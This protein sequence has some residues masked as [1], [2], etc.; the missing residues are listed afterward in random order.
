MDAFV[1]VGN[2]SSEEDYQIQFSYEERPDG[3]EAFTTADLEPGWNLVAPT[4]V[5]YAVATDSDSLPSDGQAFKT[6]NG[7]IVSAAQLL[8]GGDR[9]PM[10]HGE[11]KIQRGLE[12]NFGGP[13]PVAVTSPYEGYWV[14]SDDAELV[15]EVPGGTSARLE[16]E[17]LSPNMAIYELLEELFYPGVRPIGPG[18]R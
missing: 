17:G 6:V 8:E 16:L 12:G 10:S 1:V 5:G 18:I 7:D 13:F 3:Q 4:Q 14:A 15:S 11:A 9:Q 2:E